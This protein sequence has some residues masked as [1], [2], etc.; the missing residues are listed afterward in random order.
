MAGRRGNSRTVCS[1]SV[2]TANLVRASWTCC[3]ASMC[4]GAVRREFREPEGIGP[5]QVARLVKPLGSSF[6]GGHL[7]VEIIRRLAETVSELLG[8]GVV[9][10][11]G[12]RGQAVAN[13]AQ[14]IPQL[15][16]AFGV[17]ASFPQPGLRDLVLQ[18]E[19]ALGVLKLTLG[20]PRQ[21]FARSRCPHW[22]TSGMPKD[23][24]CRH[25]RVGRWRTR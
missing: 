21:L 7:L 4:S 1:A 5:Q 20:G 13:R 14:G 6:R 17:A 8:G 3:T 11:G 2:P 19:P 9:E 15:L 10:Q 23:P 18:G 16:Q 24:G 25:R 12:D 22:W